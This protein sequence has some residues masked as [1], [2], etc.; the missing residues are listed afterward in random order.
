MR[1]KRCYLI[2]VLIKKRSE[3]GLRCVG[4][5]KMLKTLKILDQGNNEGE[6]KH[7]HVGIKH[8]D[9]KHI[10]LVALEME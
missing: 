1:L 8:V 5:C 10:R 4:K 9:N 3:L 6:K 2:N 7:L